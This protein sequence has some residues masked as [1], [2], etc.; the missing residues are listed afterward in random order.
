MAFP[1]KIKRYLELS[2]YAFLSLMVFSAGSAFW[3]WNEYQPKLAEL[4]GKDPD[5]FQEMV[6]AAKGLELGQ[7]LDDFRAIDQMTDWDVYTLRYTKWKKRFE[8]DGEFRDKHLEARSDRYGRLKGERWDEYGRRQDRLKAVALNNPE[9]KRKAWLAKSPWGKT[10]LL[11]EGC[12]R[13]LEME[14]KAA[15]KRQRLDHPAHDTGFLSPE[16][17]VGTTPAEECDRLVTVSHSEEVAEQSLANVQR[18]MNYYF[19]T[20]MSEELGLPDSKRHDTDDRLA[21][22]AH[23]FDAY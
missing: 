11:K 2:L 19:F 1:K 6:L 17:V 15:L 22:M 20:V 10:V 21:K 14:R 9:T 8:E 12:M 3:L 5:R 7:A 13:Y 23:D 16:R 18:S 4:E